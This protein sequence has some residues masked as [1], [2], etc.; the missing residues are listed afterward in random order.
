LHERTLNVRIPKGVR[1]GQHIR[2]AKQGGAGLGAGEPGD[3]Y[4]EVDFAS[5]PFFHVEGKDVYLDLPVAPWE[6][7]LGAK[8][9]IP[10]PA[11]RLDL[12]I[13]P[14][15]GTGKKL[16]LKGKGIPAKDP[17]DLYAVLRIA[18]PPADSAS[19][20]KAYREF[21]QASNF[22]PRAGMGG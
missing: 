17:G 18:L 1:Q 19:A 8:I 6:A 9:N 15:S 22:N 20:E 11:T 7:A 2:L 13:P 5:H 14:N 12:K 4:L 3:L 21:E 10:T 16:R